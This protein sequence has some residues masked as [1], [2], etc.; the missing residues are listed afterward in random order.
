MFAS[1]D[2]LSYTLGAMNSEFA[3]EDLVTAEDSAKQSTLDKVS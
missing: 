3:L 1:G 2:T